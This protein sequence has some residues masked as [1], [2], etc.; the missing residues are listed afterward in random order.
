LRKSG[1][2]SGAEFEALPPALAG[3][4]VGFV[5]GRPAEAGSP[6]RPILKYHRLKPVA[7]RKGKASSEILNGFVAQSLS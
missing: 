1:G 3:G 5:M 7:K 4:Y 2:V 6:D